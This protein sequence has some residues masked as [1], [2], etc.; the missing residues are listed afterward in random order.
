MDESLRKQLVP[1]ALV[2]IIQQIARRDIDRAW[3]STVR[4]TIVSYEQRQTGSWFAHAKA[5]KLWL[6][7]LMIRKEDGEV[8]V[9][10]LDDYSVVKVLSSAGGEVQAQSSGAVTGEMTAK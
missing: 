6:D 3:T 5:D 4:G 10:N 2:E 8:T 9:L 7:R 1:G